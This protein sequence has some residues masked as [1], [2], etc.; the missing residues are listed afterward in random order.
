MTTERGRLVGL[1]VIV[2]TVVLLVRLERVLYGIN[3]I[4][5]SWL[6]AM[7]KISR[8]WKFTSKTSRLINRFMF[9]RKTFPDS[10]SVLYRLY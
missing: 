7:K 10:V 5:K 8:N 1:S 2:G 4:N 3:D 6:W 9:I